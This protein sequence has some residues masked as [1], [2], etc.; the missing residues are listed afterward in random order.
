MIFIKASF[1]FI[2]G[3]NKITGPTN[4]TGSVIA[5]TGGASTLMFALEGVQFFPSG[6]SKTS[7]IN[8]YLRALTLSNEGANNTIVDVPFMKMP[9]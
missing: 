3:K 1:C 5:H 9:Q 2:G 4:S 7:R 6:S 8:S